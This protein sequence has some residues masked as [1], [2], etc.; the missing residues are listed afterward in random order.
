MN[1]FWNF[2]LGWLKLQTSCILG[3]MSEGVSRCE[4]EHTS[5]DSDQTPMH[6]HNMWI[7]TNAHP[8]IHIKSCHQSRRTFM[9]IKC[10]GQ[11]ASEARVAIWRICIFHLF[12]TCMCTCIYTCI[13]TCFWTC[14]W[15][16]IQTCIWTCIGNCFCCC[17]CEFNATQPASQ[18][19]VAL[20]GHHTCRSGRDPAAANAAFHCFHPLLVLPSGENRSAS[21]T[22][23]TALIGVPCVF[24][25]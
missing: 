7:C 4:A 1:L 21:P 13:Q 18:A 15:T 14:V 12:C 9:W 25:M 5:L 10:I 23:P 11:L 22:P 20:R 24:I 2:K 17:F 8:V 6:K 19:M 3:R 16:C